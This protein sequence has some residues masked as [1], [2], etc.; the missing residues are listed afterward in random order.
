MN[1]IFCDHAMLSPPARLPPSATAAYA[2]LKRSLLACATLDLRGAPTR[3][4]RGGRVYW[5]DSYRLGTEV[6]KTYLGEDSDTL[7][8]RLLHARALAQAEDERRAERARL[9]RLLRA[10]GLAGTVGGAG[11]FLSAL[12]AAGAFR[13]GLTVVGAAAFR[14]YEAELGIRLDVAEDAT[15]RLMLALPA[16]PSENLLHC[17]AGFSFDPVPSLMRERSWRWRQA[18]GETLAGFVTQAR[19]DDEAPVYIKQ[20]GVYAEPKPGLEWLIAEP[21]Q[22]AVPWRSGVIINIPKPE[23]FAI[24]HGSDAM[25]AALDP[26]DVEIARREAAAPTR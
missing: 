1:E 11:S 21:I 14:L 25:L 13:H 15:H 8:A 9:V 12:A 7:R 10:E 5:Y 26:H 18:R 20:L 17:L 24:H 3:V 22:A 4:Q 16:A 19:A 2:E 23:R 6:R